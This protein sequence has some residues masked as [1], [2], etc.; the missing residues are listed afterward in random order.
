MFFNHFVNLCHKA[1]GFGERHDNLLVM[2]PVLGGQG[3]AF[4]IFQP[5]LADLVAANVEIPDLL[6]HAPETDGLGFV[7]PDGVLGP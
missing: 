7:Q 6:A 5:F 2:L 4:A 3:T 1:D